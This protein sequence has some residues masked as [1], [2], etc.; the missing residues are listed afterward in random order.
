MYKLFQISLNRR[1]VD[2]INKNGW[3]VALREI[4]IKAYI[5]ARHHADVDLAIEHDLLVHVADVD[6]SGLEQAFVVGNMGPEEKLTRHQTMSSISVGD[7]LVDEDGLA[8]V[9]DHVG[10]REVD[11]PQVKDNQTF[12]L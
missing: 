7:V 5:N 10:W 4:A 12:S 11:F 6:A 2:L 9:C 1:Q 3:E 8:H